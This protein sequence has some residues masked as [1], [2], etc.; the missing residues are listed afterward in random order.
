L[1]GKNFTPF[2]RFVKIAFP[3]FL[4]ELITM[5]FLHQIKIDNYFLNSLID[6]GILLLLL[7]PGLYFFI[8]KEM[9]MEEKIFRSNQD[10]ENTFNSITDM[11]TIHDGDYNI[12]RANKAAQVLLRLPI[13]KLDHVKCFR[14]Y[15]GTEAPPAQCPSCECLRDGKPLTVEIYEPHLKMHLELRA[16]P[17]YDTNGRII[18]LIH[19]ARDI[20]K[21]KRREQ[22]LEAVV[23][24]SS[25]IRK[26]R[27]RAEMLPLVLEKALELANVE[28]AALVFPAPKEGHVIELAAGEWKPVT[29]TYLPRGKGLSERVISA[30]EPYLNKN[31]LENERFGI[32]EHLRGINSVAGIPLMVEKQCIGALW[33]GRQTEIF[34]EDLS[35]LT[36]IAAIAAN[37]IKRITLHDQTEQ[38]LSRLGALRAVDSA[39]TGSLDLRIIFNVLLDH[40]F[41]QLR[42][43]AASVLLLEP[44]SSN[45]ECAAARGFRTLCLQGRKPKI[46]N[47]LAGRAVLERTTV[48]MPDIA[49]ISVPDCMLHMQDEEFRSY[50]AVPL[51]A[52]GQVKGVL[53]L[54][55][56]DRHEPDPEWTEFMESLAMQ[57]AI[58]IDN[59][60]LF[61]AMERSNLELRIAYDT[62]LDGWSRALDLR[63]RE[64]EGHTQRVAD[65]TVRIA[66]KLNLKDEELVHIRRGALLH[67]IGKMGIPDSVLL[68]PGVLTEQEWKIMRMHPVFAY[69]LLSPIKFLEPALDIPYCHH[70]KWDGTGYPRGL[71]GTQIP[72]AARIFAVVDVW[73]AL[74]SDRPYRA[75]W[76]AEMVIGHIRSL[77][78]T[79]FDPIVVEKFLELMREDE[80]L[81]QESLQKA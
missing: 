79:H 41:S 60:T 59:S 29:G 17:R 20:S 75:A 1:R 76:S 10:W 31:V 3:V 70:E 22:E 4:A 32:L 57:T 72:L 23:A 68:K 78:G 25:A 51:I 50:M 6:S 35:V 45:L 38:R 9:K 33:I 19:I 73:D 43:D 46:G 81:N 71:K 26:A 8:Y 77:S 67:D 44:N 34:E 21:R 27:T 14:H 58:A 30:G 13:A 47:C 12:I 63:D 15:H 40:I 80:L 61:Y 18:G 42:V 65:L 48:N 53:E 62:T 56:K 7:S 28:G 2:S 24:I 74:R 55:F 52:K 69:E 5:H 11:V 49:G 64:T 54:F 37:A 66:R 36:A 39:I 16:L